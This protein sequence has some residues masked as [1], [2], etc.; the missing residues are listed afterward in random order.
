[1]RD[2]AFENGRI[3]ARRGLRAELVLIQHRDPS[4]ASE[5]KRV[6][7]P[8]LPEPITTTSA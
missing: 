2:V 1:V 8:N 3:F 5:T 6:G 7:G 4:G